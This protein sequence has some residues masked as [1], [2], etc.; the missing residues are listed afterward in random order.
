MTAIAQAERELRR[1]LS[2][3]FGWRLAVQPSE[4]PQAPDEIGDR[5]SIGPLSFSDLDRHGC[6]TIDVLHAT[7]WERL[8]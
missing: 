5:G 6:L 7:T 3:S 4:Q 2:S 1:N 8:L